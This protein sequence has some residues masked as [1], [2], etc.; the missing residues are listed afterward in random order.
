MLNLLTAFKTMLGFS[1]SFP[2][3]E[4]LSRFRDKP[5]FPVKVYNPQFKTKLTFITFK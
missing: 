4:K 5:Y 1:F 2:E 3:F